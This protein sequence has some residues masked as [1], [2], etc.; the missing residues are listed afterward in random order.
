VE[1][2][3]LNVP[4]NLGAKEQKEPNEDFAEKLKAEE[5]VM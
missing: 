1:E 4:G 2:R 3:F 5:L